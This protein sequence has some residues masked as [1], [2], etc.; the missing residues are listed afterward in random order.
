MN[1]PDEALIRQHLASC[2]LEELWNIA[3]L[4]FDFIDDTPSHVVRHHHIERHIAAELTGYDEFCAKWYRCQSAESGLATWRGDVV[5]FDWVK[6][7]HPGAAAYF[8]WAGNVPSSST[9]S[10]VTRFELWPCFERILMAAHQDKVAV[11]SWLDVERELLPV[12]V[13]KYLA[14]RRADGSDAT[15]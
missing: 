2:T 7:T 14:S 4:R 12:A 9:L 3:D 11:E 5:S 10:K 6:E 1:E 8:I 13:S 15:Q